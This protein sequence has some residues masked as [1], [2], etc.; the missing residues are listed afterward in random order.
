MST[1]EPFMR[2][3]TAVAQPLLVFSPAIIRLLIAGLEA[4]LVLVSCSFL[5]QLAM[6]PGIDSGLP[7]SLAGWLSA[8][9]SDLASRRV[10]LEA[11]TGPALAVVAMTG[12]LA[13]LVGRQA[14]PLLVRLCLIIALWS[15]TANGVAT[16]VGRGFMS[17]D[18]IELACLG[19]CASGVLAAMLASAVWGTRR[20]CGDCDRATVVNVLAYPGWLLFGGLGN[21]WLVDFAAHGYAKYAYIGVYQFDAWLLANLVLTICAACLQNL[22]SSVSRLLARVEGGRFGGMPFVLAVALSWVFGIV[23]LARMMDTRLLHVAGLSEALR[24]PVWFALAW[25]TYRWVDNGLRPVGG[26]FAAGLLLACMVLALFLVDDKGPIL[27]QAVAVSLL[28][29]SMAAAPI[30]QRISPVVGVSLA[31]GLTATLLF[32]I[33]W[34]VFRYAPHD[35]LEALAHP[36]EG[37]LEFLSEIRWFLHG[38]PIDG[39]GLGRV[40]WCGNSAVQGATACAGVPRQIQSDY[41]FAALAGIWGVG[42]AMLLILALLAWLATL[43]VARFDRSSGRAVDLN[44]LAGWLVAGGATAYATQI[45]VSTLG[46]LGVIP[47]TGVSIPLLAYGGSSLITLGLLTG[48]A[49]NSFP[50]PVRQCGVAS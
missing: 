35:R 16:G 5:W 32:A 21:L 27:V 4:L 26:I 37:A 44:N 14:S 20:E 17:R 8:L 25:L 42:M 24:V 13:L 36:H 7:S 34:G 15:L 2:T 22:L 43:V 46:T 6:Q 31:V 12:W 45:M 28:L 40:P 49:V 11:N 1:M 48:M 3:P 38:A 39:Y 29:G 33:Y 19:M 50:R 41:V 10:W 30:W 18:A 9:P 23:C 47:L